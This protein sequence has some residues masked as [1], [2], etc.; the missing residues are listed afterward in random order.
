MNRVA[1]SSV[2][3]CGG[4]VW[5]SVVKERGGDWIRQL[6]NCTSSKYK[7]L[8]KE[9]DQANEK[10][11]TYNNNSNKNNTSRLSL[12][13]QLLFPL[14]V[15]TWPQAPRRAPGPGHSIWSFQR[16]AANQDNVEAIRCICGLMAPSPLPI[17]NGQPH[18]L[19]TCTLI[20]HETTSS[21]SLSR[22]VGIYESFNLLK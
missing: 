3:V 11:K 4:G 6:L 21:S 1:E 12:P 14:A 2:G 13:W 10:E 22:I 20:M 9:T 17:A 8:D 19:C 15:S 7:E 18:H 5:E 16:S